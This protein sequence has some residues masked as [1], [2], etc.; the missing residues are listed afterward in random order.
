[1]GHIG[2]HI[3]Q[4]FTNVRDLTLG[5]SGWDQVTDKGMT[6]LID[7]ITTNVTKLERLTL[8]FS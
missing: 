8:D 2:S 3:A 5:F 7:H 4:Y 1:L 6:Q